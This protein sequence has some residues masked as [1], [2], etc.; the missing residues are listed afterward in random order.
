MQ[1]S[2]DDHAT[3]TSDASSKS[4]VQ[5]AVTHDGETRDLVTGS[6]IETVGDVRE[7]RTSGYTLPVTLTERGATAFTT[8][9]EQFGAFDE[10]SAYEI[11]TSF[12]GERVT[13]ATL[14]RSLA[15]AME[16]GDWDGSLVI[17][18]SDR[19]T[20]ERLRDALGSE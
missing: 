1:T 17:G 13:A 18:V 15:H 20:A 7:G 8:T 19:A 14:G 16:S 10:P 5:I 3:A 2:T 4:Q 11:T 6:A 12:R 9:L